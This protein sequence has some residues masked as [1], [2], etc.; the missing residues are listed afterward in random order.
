MLR[1]ISFA[2]LLV[3]STGLAHAEDDLIGK[4]V[5]TSDAGAPFCTDRAQLQEYMMALLQ[6]DDKWRSSL[7]SCMFVKNGVKFAVIEEYPGS[8]IGHVVKGRL[9][10]GSSSMLGYTLNLGLKTK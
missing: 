5:V 7:D 10:A 2:T 1:M 4:D 6:H 3:A 8:D 9:I